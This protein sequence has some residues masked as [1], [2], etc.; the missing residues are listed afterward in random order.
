MIRLAKRLSLWASLP[1]F[2]LLQKFS[3]PAVLYILTLKINFLR[4]DHSQCWYQIPT[5][6][7]SI[8][9]VVYLQHLPAPE[10]FAHIL[11]MNVR[12]LVENS[13]KW[14]ENKGNTRK[15]AI[16]KNWAHVVDFCN[17]QIVDQ[18]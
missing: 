2:G 5:C 7:L 16:S 14:A 4:G 15:R 18:I 11:M 10:Y 3:G 1:I 17:D 9:S 13:P 12:L 8:D 6:S